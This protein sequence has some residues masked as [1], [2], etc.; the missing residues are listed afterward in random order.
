LRSTP[1]TR[2]RIRTVAADDQG[3]ISG[4]PAAAAPT[5]GRAEELLHRHLP[6]HFRHHRATVVGI[7]RWLDDE[8]VA[9]V[10][11]RIDH[12]LPTNAQREDLAAVPHRPWDIERLLDGEHLDRLAGRDLAKQRDPNRALHR[13]RLVQRA[14][15]VRLLF[16]YA[17]RCRR[18]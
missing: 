5:A 6:V 18:R 4:S 13:P 14:P 11:A 12:R 3:S 9:V 15:H 16:A 17:R 8:V 7:L 2:P 10:D 1:T